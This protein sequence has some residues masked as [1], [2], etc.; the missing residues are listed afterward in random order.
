MPALRLR[1]L[2]T[3]ANEA[4]D[5]GDGHLQHVMDGAAVVGHLRHVVPVPPAF[6]DLAV[7]AHVVE[8]RQ[9]DLQEAPT[10]AFRVG[11]LGVEAEVRGRHLV[12]GWR[13]PAGWR[14][15]CRRMSPDW[16]GTNALRGVD[17][18][19]PPRRLCRYLPVGTG[20]CR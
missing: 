15:T 4:D 6:T 8:E 11:T 12:G 17:R 2:S 14:R 5:V 3:D 16:N 13:T 9:L 20:G 19:R 18:R 10:S 1:G 7:Q